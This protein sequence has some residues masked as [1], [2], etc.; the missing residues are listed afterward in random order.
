MDACQQNGGEKDYTHTHHD[1]S[2]A[3]PPS[4]LPDLGQRQS[5]TD[6]TYIRVISAGKDLA[7]DA[8]LE[9]KWSAIDSR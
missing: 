5:L 2:P 8:K 6:D 7:H 3:R 1:D 4:V 9:R